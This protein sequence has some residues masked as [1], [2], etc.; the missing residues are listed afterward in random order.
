MDTHWIVGKDD[1]GSADYSFEDESSSV[2]E[3]SE[4]ERKK[5]SRENYQRR[6]K[7]KAQKLMKI[8]K[9]NK[10]SKRFRE[11]EIIGEISSENRERFERKIS[12]KNRFKKKRKRLSDRLRKPKKKRATGKGPTVSV[13]NTTPFES[14]LLAKQVKH[15]PSHHG[16]DTEHGYFKMPNRITQSSRRTTRYRRKSNPRLNQTTVQM[17][18]KM[19]YSRS[20]NLRSMNNSK[21][22]KQRGKLLMEHEANRLPEN[23]SSLYQREFLADESGEST[24]D[25]Y[26]PMG[27]TSLVEFP[28]ALD[29]TSGNFDLMQQNRGNVLHKLDRKITG[30][31]RKK[32]IGR[33]VGSRPRTTTDKYVRTLRNY[34]LNSSKNNRKKFRK[35]DFR[36][37]RAF[38]LADVSSESSTESSTDSSSSYYTSSS[39]E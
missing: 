13:Q 20:H 11:G 34:K 30:K 35:E 10:K 38:N 6:K 32:E 4:E 26:D 2:S 18:K 39:E 16:F 37:Q 23:A 19:A 7:K 8:G 3:D 24:K 1:D 25:I 31:K 28:D 12:A 22:G 36:L 14:S 5:R 21:D 29:G 33:K 17:G 27:D 15:D 9:I